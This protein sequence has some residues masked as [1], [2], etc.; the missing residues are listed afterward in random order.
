MKII[1]LLAVLF[2]STILN[3]QV[4]P[5][6]ILNDSINSWQ[7]DLNEDQN[8][9]LL[10]T[11]EEAVENLGSMGLYPS[12]ES[13]FFIDADYD[14]YTDLLQEGMIM[15]T[16][17]YV[18]F[19]GTKDGF[20][21]PSYISGYLY[22]TSKPDGIHPLSLEVITTP[23]CGG[24]YF[25]YR[26]CEPLKTDSG[27]IY[28]DTDLIY[29]FDYYKEEI[30]DIYEDEG[31]ICTV[32]SDSAQ[33][34]VSPGEEDGVLVFDQGNIAAIYAKDARFRIVLMRSTENGEHW[35]LL[36]SEP[37]TTEISNSVFYSPLGKNE[38][39]MGWMKAD[40]LTITE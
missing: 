17:F 26:K 2:L 7:L 35:F 5:K 18:F 30:G 11:A 13:S 14:G 22:S 31:K 19:P 39:I 28:K 6:S 3:A 33:L 10:K 1:G 25:T 8:N 29:F 16:I 9:K 12:L 37:G 21:P 4:F 15:G 32:I 23:C 24:Y 40:K 27:L 38:Q 20:G 36:L 34:L